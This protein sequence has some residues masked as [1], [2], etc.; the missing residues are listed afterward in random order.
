[1]RSPKAQIKDSE[2]QAARKA[3]LAA[4]LKE[5]LN[6]RRGVVNKAKPDSNKPNSKNEG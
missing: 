4:A 5:N 6:R 1:M 3:R 2:R